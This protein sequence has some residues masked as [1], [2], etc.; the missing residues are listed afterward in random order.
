[1]KKILQIFLILG[2]LFLIGC[3]GTNPDSD[4]NRPEQADTI[5]AEESGIPAAEQ[6]INT[7]NNSN[8]ESGEDEDE[9]SRDNGSENK[10]NKNDEQK[11]DRYRTSPTP[12]GQ[13]APAEPQDADIDP[14]TE[15]HCTLSITCATILDNQDSFNETKLEVLPEDGIIYTKKEAV[16]YEGESVFDVLLRE[17]K[18]NKIHMEF[19]AT[20]VYNSNYIEGINNIYEFDCGEL[21]GWMYKVNGWFPNYGCSRYCL[22]P[23]EPQDAD[24]DP[25]TEY[26]CTLSITC[27]T[28][29]DNQDSFNETKLEVLP[30]DGIIYTKKEAVFYEGESVFD[31]LLRETKENKIHMEFVAT[32]VYN[33]NYIEGIN[34]IYEFDCGELSGWMYKVNGWFPNYGCSRYCLQDGDKIEW[35]YTCNLGKDVGGDWNAQYQKE[36]Q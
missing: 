16:F 2:I 28:I 8:P 23:A 20:P 3:G 35:V 30:E 13:P 33:S 15:Y 18:E 34:N 21:S 26:H 22:H 5:I 12:E 17:T 11:P 24:I 14:K 27:A 1:M 36:E 10:S 32:P 31:V 6:E 19:V 4:M 7:N 29:L 25:K 9:G